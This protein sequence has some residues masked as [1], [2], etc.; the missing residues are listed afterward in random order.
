MN[1]IDCVYIFYKKN[2]SI[3]EYRWNKFFLSVDVVLLS[4]L[5]SKEQMT[6]KSPNFNRSPNTWL[7][8]EMRSGFEFVVTQIYYIYSLK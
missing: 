1:R 5:Q 4:V 8:N 7:E 3:F 2:V 6:Q